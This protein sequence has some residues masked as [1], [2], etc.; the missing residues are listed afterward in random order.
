MTLPVR[1]TAAPVARRG[2]WARRLS[3]GAV[4]STLPVLFYPGNWT[5]HAP[6]AASSVAAW[7]V[8]AVGTF[9]VM[10]LGLAWTGWTLMKWPTVL[11]AA[12][13]RNVL[14][15]VR[16]VILAG[17]N[18][19]ALIVSG[20][21]YASAFAVFAGVVSFGSGAGGSPESFFVLCC[22]Y[23][24]VTPGFVVEVPPGVQLA[25]NPL[26]LLVFLVGAA[27]FAAN[28]AV[29]VELLR[30]R[31][32]VRATPA[33]GVIGAAG[34]LLVGCPS[35]GTI[36]AASALEGTAA[37]GL[38]TGWAIL[39]LP[40]LLSAIP[41]AAGGLWASGRQL[42]RLTVCSRPMDRGVDQDDL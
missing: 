42:S 13:P 7:S 9:A 2:A 40:L 8:D 21:G 16:E 5:T 30:R 15:D 38:L 24:G 34:T 18:R 41:L 23:P 22:G 29:T 35:C 25:V 33:Y 31:S 17:R 12:H 37:A 32:A 10:A 11:S 39:Q 4:A 3:L 6:A 20:I 36:L 28:I 27:L 1:N 19:L 26:T 14:G